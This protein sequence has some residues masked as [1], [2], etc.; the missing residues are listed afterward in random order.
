LSNSVE[1]SVETTGDIAS[2]KPG[3][4]PRFYQSELDLLRLAAFLLVF[5]H[6]LLPETLGPGYSNLAEQIFL[7]FKFASGNGLSLFFLLSSYLITE[8]LLREQ[9]A[10]G[11]I[12]IK[13]FYIRR[14][15]RIWPLYFAFIAFG[16][17]LGF[18]NKGLH[19]TG[20]FLAQYALL[21]GN[22]AF[23]HTPTMNPIGPLWSI[24]IEE[25]FYLCWPSVA[26]KF[27]RRGILFLSLALIPI[28][29]LASVWLTQ[30][31]EKPGFA[32]WTHSLTEFEC[33]GAGALLAL[34][35]HHRRWMPNLA[36]RLAL[37]GGGVAMWAISDG[38]FHYKRMQMLQVRDLAPQV[39]GFQLV[40]LGCCLIFLTVLGARVSASVFKPLLYLGRISYGLYVYHIFAR[41][42]AMRLFSIM[43]VRDFPA[44]SVQNFLLMSVALGITIALASTSY[45]YF[46]KRFLRLKERFAIVKTRVD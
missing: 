6:H 39:I 20:L 24:S 22:F 44:L 17:L 15:L 36:A 21:L 14:I 12:A 28:S 31:A 13:A 33:F 19:I 11:T 2:V 9:E 34:A 4:A 5:C 46:E 27:G 41:Y 32:I 1:T 37:F 18:A 8:L 10:T 7:T 26:R 23:Y 43:H 3:R 29:I 42:V 25:Q 30:T 35:L 16:Y 45:K 38:F 40:P